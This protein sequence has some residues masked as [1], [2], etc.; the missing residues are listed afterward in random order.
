MHSGRWPQP[1][2][3]IF[4]NTR[5]F[6]PPHQKCQLGSHRKDHIL[7]TAGP[8]ERKGGCPG[9]RILSSLPCIGADE[10]EY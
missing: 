3:A 5:F 6:T 10:L 4:G 2:R 8:S 9:Y 7:N 1:N